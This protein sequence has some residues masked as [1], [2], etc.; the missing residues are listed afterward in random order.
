MNGRPSTQTVNKLSPSTFNIPRWVIILPSSSRTCMSK[1]RIF[2]SNKSWW[3]I[4]ENASLE[5]KYL[6]QKRYEKKM[7]IKSFVNLKKIFVQKIT[8]NIYDYFLSGFIYRDCVRIFFIKNTFLWQWTWKVLPWVI[9]QRAFWHFWL[10]LPKFKELISVRRYICTCAFDKTR[11]LKMHFRR[12]FE[13]FRKLNY[14][15]DLY[16]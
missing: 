6:Y 9:S 13:Y 14:F 4:S 11:L 16:E 7:K 8:R 5:E 10:W 3:V 12:Y 15:R 1:L 2:C